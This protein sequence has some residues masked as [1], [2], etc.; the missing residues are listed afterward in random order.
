LECIPSA[1]F[2]TSRLWGV[3]SEIFIKV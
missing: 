3:I 1:A 2:S